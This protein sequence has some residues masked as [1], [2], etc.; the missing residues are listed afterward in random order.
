[1]CCLVV[2]MRYCVLCKL[3]WLYIQYNAE[4]YM[5][6]YLLLSSSLAACFF[7]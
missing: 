1:M 5:E 2:I 3:K 6:M 4:I 7:F